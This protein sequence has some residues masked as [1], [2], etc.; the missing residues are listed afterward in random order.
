LF[1]LELENPLFAD[2]F[3][4][5]SL[6]LT[7][8]IVTILAGIYPALVMSGFNPV[9]ALKNKIN[10]GAQKKLRLRWGLVT[11]QFVIAQ[12]FIIGTIVVIQQMEYFRHADLGFD[13]EAVISVRL[14]DNQLSTIQTLK[15]QWESNTNIQ[16]ISFSNT[17]PSGTGKNGSWQDIRRKGAPEGEEGIVFEHQSIDE[18]YLDLYKIPLL[19]GRNFIPTDTMQSIILNQTLAERA[20]F[21]QPEDAVGETMMV[22]GDAFTVVGITEDFHTS[23]LKDE[24]GYL[25]FT[26]MPKRYRT[27]NIKLS[28]TPGTAGSAGK[29]QEAIGQVE[30]AWT[31]TYPDYVFEYQFLDESIAAYYREETRLSQLFKMLA[32]VTIFIG[33]LGLYGL[34]AFM[35]VRRTKEVGIRKVL[36]ASVQNILVLFSKE[37]ITLVLIAFCIA[38]PVAFY[39]MRQWLSNFAY[40]IDMGAGV[41]LLAIGASIL[42]AVL[43]VSYQS[44]KAALMNPVES[45]RNE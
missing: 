37:F 42:I 25:A 35:A 16:A 7:I 12:V 18:I 30:K 26:M 39:V 1:Q 44:L 36:G 40:R 11:L 23:S 34:V 15:N 43:T 33:C 19:A 4:W 20:G 32:G 22:F 9:A 13:Q 17:L 3:I 6:L 28:V 38:G 8:F 2:P 21:A 14:P 31:A 41:F 45:L 5:L 10:A 24:I 29:I 27:A